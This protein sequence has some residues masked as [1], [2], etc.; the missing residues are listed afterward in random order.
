M[1]IAKWMGVDLMPI[2]AR[3]QDEGSGPAPCQGTALGPLQHGLQM[4]LPDYETGRL[5][6]L[7]AHAPGT[8]FGQGCASRSCA[9]RHVAPATTGKWRGRFARLRALGYSL[10]APV[11]SGA[12]K[13][14]EACHLAEQ[15]KGT[16][17]VRN[18]ILRAVDIAGLRRAGIA[19]RLHLGSCVGLADS[20]PATQPI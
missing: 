12:E 20:G 18:S 15:F 11:R 2:L 6:P 14:G 3:L 8:A 17:L 13:R 4:A 5:I 9:G 7:A 1:L 10:D 19:P 16:A